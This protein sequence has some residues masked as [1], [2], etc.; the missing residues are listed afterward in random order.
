MEHYVKG[1]NKEL[2]IRLNDIPIPEIPKNITLI[3]VKPSSK[4]S[5]LLKTSMEVLE[6]QQC[7]L[8]TGEGPAISKTISCIEILKRKYPHLKQLTRVSFKRCE[9]YWNANTPG[10][11]SLKVVR[12]VPMIH[13]LLILYQ[14][15][16]KEKAY[17]YSRNFCINAFSSSNNIRL[18]C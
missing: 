9:E 1:E 13:I 2:S 17:N 5:C 18:C 6:H 7:Q 15:K 3:I 11:D 16:F 8:W 12:N 10:M 4:I 14:P